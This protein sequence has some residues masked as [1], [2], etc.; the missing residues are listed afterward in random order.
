MGV[1]SDL[2]GR[3]ATLLICLLLHI[4]ASAWIAL[5]SSI[6][7]MIV[8]RVVQALGSATVYI[9]LRLVIKDTMDTR[10]QIH[11]TGLLVIGLVL[12]PILAPAIGAWITALSTW[13]NCFWAIVALEIPLFVWA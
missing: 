6:S 13:R 3:R 10:V 11:A 1:V 9:V 4:V 8:M 7:I 2:H 5:C 12:S